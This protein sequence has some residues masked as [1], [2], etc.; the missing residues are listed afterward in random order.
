[1]NITRLFIY[2]VLAFML[3][4]IYSC[5]TTKQCERNVK[6]AIACGLIKDSIS[7]RVTTKDSLVFIKG[8]DIETHDTL[9]KYVECP[10]GKKP[11]F[12]AHSSTT[13]KNNSTSTTTIDTNG[14]ITI[15]CDCADS[16]LKFQA[17]ITEKDR[18]ISTINTINTK[19]LTHWQR[20]K[21]DFKLFLSSFVLGMLFMYL[22]PYIYKLTKPLIKTLFV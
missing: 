1:M 4:L 15:E 10:D 19:Q 17:I 16:I 18:F 13:R 14:K 2:L 12:H 6:K 7:Y 5:S 22:L 11:I 3:S 8:D 20:F 21:K 9:T